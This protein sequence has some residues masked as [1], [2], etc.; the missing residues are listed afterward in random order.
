MQIIFLGTNGWYDTKTGNTPC[1]FIKTETHNIII[2][3]GNGFSK[4]SAYLKNKKP[5]HLFISHLHL[6]HIE[7]LHTLPQIKTIDKLNLFVYKGMKKYI[8]S[9]LKEP[10]TA[11]INQ[12]NFSVEISELSEGRYSLPYLLEVKPLKHSVPVMGLRFEVEGKIITYCSDTGICKNSEYLAKKADILIHECSWRIPKNS[13]WGHS[14]SEEVSLLAKKAKVK[15]LYLSHFAA[16]EF[17]N[18]QQRKEAEEKAR[19]IF[20]KTFAAK[21]NL[22]VDL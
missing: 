15:R 1:V 17:V 11:N 19:K 20:P 18:L 22:V 9:F 3:A 5:T 7:G 12:L 10:Y 2:D 16:D 4:V 14:T 13:N 8:L 21:D 6:D